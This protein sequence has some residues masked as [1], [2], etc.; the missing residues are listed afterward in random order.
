VPRDEQR[1]QIEI[2]GVAVIVA[3]TLGM[4]AVFEHLRR[5]LVQEDVAAARHARRARA[6]L[7]KR[8]RD[9][10]QSKR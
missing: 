3:R 4:A 7:R 5:R 8:E 10:V 6:K 9:G 2:G 1:E